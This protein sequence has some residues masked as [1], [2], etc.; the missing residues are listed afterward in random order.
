M[1]KLFGSAHVIHPWVIKIVYF[2]KF[3]VLV[4]QQGIYMV[5]INLLKR[6]STVGPFM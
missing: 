3:I 5:S 1:M 6:R 2:F 4:Y